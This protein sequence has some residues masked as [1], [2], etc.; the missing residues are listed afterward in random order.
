MKPVP[1]A[2][3][4]GHPY[5]SRT[6]VRGVA[7][8]WNVVATIHPRMFKRAQRLL[9]EFGPVQKTPYLNVLV[10]RVEDRSAFL[11]GLRRRFPKEAEEG[12]PL[13]RVL[14]AS[15]IFSFQRA[16]EFR[17][18]SSEILEEWSS[19]LAGHSFHVRVHRRGFKARLASA[20]EECRLGGA[21]L[22]AVWKEKEDARVLL[23][24]SDFVIAVETVGGRAGMA[25]LGRE[26]LRLYPFL[27]P[28]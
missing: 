17:A 5:L 26:E 13:A 9:A 12:F 16:E 1:V 28:D 3:R 21:A 15:R 24:D 10:L 11:E 6:P 14:P 25:L 23:K 7:L 22:Q 19:I 20:E 2:R 27:N 18:R 8:E 4:S